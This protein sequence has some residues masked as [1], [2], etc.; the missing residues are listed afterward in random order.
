MPALSCI[1]SYKSKD[2]MLFLQ[3]G[4][5][6]VVTVSSLLSSAGTGSRASL[7]SSAC[8]FLG[9]TLL[10]FRVIAIGALCGCIWHSAYNVAEVVELFVLHY[11]GLHVLREDALGAA[12]FGDAGAGGN[13]ADHE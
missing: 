4:S 8:A 5:S 13:E 7:S 6:E 11:G 10:V 3:G 9:C 1:C 12:L 2:L